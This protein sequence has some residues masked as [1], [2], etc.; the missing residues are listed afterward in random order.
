MQRL[1]SEKRVTVVLLEFVRFLL[2]RYSA[3]GGIPPYLIENVR[4]L[5]LA[6]QVRAPELKSEENIWQCEQ[7]VRMSNAVLRLVRIEAG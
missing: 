7:R 3:G 1:N 4:P 6:V 2:P 5:P